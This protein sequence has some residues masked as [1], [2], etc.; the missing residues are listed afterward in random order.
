M[1]ES[2]L[3]L[4]IKRFLESQNYAVKGEVGHCDVLAVRGDEVPV[5]VELKLTLNLDVLL[6]A[7][8]RLALTPKV[9]IGV[10]TSC[11]AL[12]RRE[13]HVVKLLR[14][15]GVGLVVI[16][17]VR[18]GVTKWVVKEVARRHLPADIVDRR[19]LGFRVPMD[20]WLR[21]GQGGGLESMAWDLLTASD[22]LATTL[23]DA[24]T[25]RG[26]LERHRS[27]TADE[28]LRIWPLLSLEVWHRTFFRDPVPAL[29][30]SGSR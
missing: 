27:G 5:V 13:T 11:A 16:D 22:S 6:Q 21:G 8:G 30:L 17:S 9:Y 18:G 12:Q 28:Q 20:A 15:L 24:R 19:K 1:K 3:Y 4:P 26:L 29:G 23:M 2:D 25:V 10:P 7:V 14:M